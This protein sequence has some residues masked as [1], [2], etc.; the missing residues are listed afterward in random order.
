MDIIIKSTT[1][2]FIQCA[3]SSD[4]N[5]N[6]EVYQPYIQRY[7]HAIRCTRET[8]TRKNMYI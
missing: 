2:S 3:Q 8:P 1:R 4:G 7:S 6:K 5:V